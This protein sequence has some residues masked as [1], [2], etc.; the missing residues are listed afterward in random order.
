MVLL[1]LTYMYLC[2]FTQRYILNSAIVLYVVART[3]VPCKRAISFFSNV[4]S[5][6]IASP[7]QFPQQECFPGFVASIND[8][9]T[10]LGWIAVYSTLNTIAS[11][12]TLRHNNAVVLKTFKL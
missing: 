8:C 5:P 12:T 10:K 3:R 11:A 4:S 9:L 2:W 1:S 6:P 7:A